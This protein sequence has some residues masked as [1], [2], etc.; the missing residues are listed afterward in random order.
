MFQGNFSVVRTPEGNI[1]GLFTG[2]TPAGPF[3]VELMAPLPFAMSGEVDKPKA[4]KIASSIMK[5]C[6]E[7]AD[8]FPIPSLV[9]AGPGA[10]SK[11]LFKRLHSKDSTMKADAH[12]KFRVLKSKAKAGDSRSMDILYAVTRLKRELDSAKDYR[13]NGNRPI[14]TNDLLFGYDYKNVVKLLKGAAKTDPSIDKGIDTY[15]RL[16][17]FISR[18]E[19]MNDYRRLKSMVAS[20]PRAGTIVQT[21][22][23]LSRAELERRRQQQQQQSTEDMMGFDFGSFIKDVGR[24][25]TRGLKTPLARN[26]LKKVMPIAKH[27][28]YIGPMLEPA[29]KMVGS[30]QSPRKSVR[31]R[32]VRK[33]KRVRRLAKAGVPKAVKARMALRSAVRI[34]RAAAVTQAIKEGAIKSK[35]RK[36]APVTREQQIAEVLSADPRL[37]LAY[38]AGSY[39]ALLK[40]LKRARRR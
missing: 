13:A 20:N 22:R 34:R 39:D 40:S 19:A 15:R 2:D 31:R 24:T 26:I 10:Y 29:L 11:K 28:P 3:S 27:L 25:V 12:Q 16:N 38:Y 14:F 7:T 30:L 17:K 37:I 1:E 33:I 21:V 4:R 18:R 32:A 9:G 5:E 8:Y 6:L 36:D 35:T 23:M